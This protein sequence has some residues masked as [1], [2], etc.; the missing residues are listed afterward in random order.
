ML[1]AISRLGALMT[2]PHRR[3]ADGW[4]HDGL[5]GHP[6]FA[7]RRAG[8]DCRL[9]VEPAGH[10]GRDYH[11]PPESRIPNPAPPLLLFRLTLRGC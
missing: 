6:T 5:E 7:G 8:V 11:A 3:E 1:R 2:N 9:H 4:C 10:K